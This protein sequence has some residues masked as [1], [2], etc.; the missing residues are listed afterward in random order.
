MSPAGGRG[1]RRRCPSRPRRDAQAQTRNPQG[2]IG[3][4]SPPIGSSSSSPRSTSTRAQHVG[5]ET[6]MCAGSDAAGSTLHPH[7]IAVLMPGSLSPLPPTTQD[8]CCHSVPR[9]A[10]ACRT[11]PPMHRTAAPAPPP[12]RAG[13]SDR[14]G[15]R[16]SMSATRSGAADASSMISHQRASN[17]GREGM[18]APMAHGR[19]Q[20]KERTHRNPPCDRAAPTET[21]YFW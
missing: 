4:A 15:G 1:R 18:P 6:R 16:R 12:R 7:P 5:R 17:S 20:L 3:A 19:L 11:G 21:A 13:M 8:E 14:T 10:R 9:V 2:P